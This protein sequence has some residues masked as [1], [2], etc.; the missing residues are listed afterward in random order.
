MLFAGLRSVRMVKNCDLRL[1]NAALGLR[2]RA[3]FSRPRSQFFTIRTSQP[4]NNIYILS[5]C[6]EYHPNNSTNIQRYCTV[7]CTVEN[8]FAVQVGARAKLSHSPSFIG[9][10]IDYSSWIRNLLLDVLVS[11]I[12]VYFYTLFVF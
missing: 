12:A 1:E 2:P 9:K 6:S 8:L 5:N 10:F 7:I 11:S 3:A 4:A